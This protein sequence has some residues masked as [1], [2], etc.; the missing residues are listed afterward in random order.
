VSLVARYLE[1]N[2]IPTVLIAN[3]RDIV[4]YC[5]VARMVFVDYPLGNPC[6]RPFEV[7][8][9]RQIFALALAQ[10]E[11]A[12]APR[13]TVQAPQQW[14]G[15]EDWKR[16]IFSNEQPFLEG[17]VYDDWIEAKK[18]YKDLKEDGKV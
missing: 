7:E 11:N 10:L 16:L 6:G 14:P 15:G 4:E 1:E 3:A 12:A 17:V 2:G 13:T 18:R 5:G 8:E 9:Q